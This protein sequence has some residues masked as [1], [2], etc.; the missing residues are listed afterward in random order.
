MNRALQFPTRRQAICLTVTVL[1]LSMAPAAAWAAAPAN[2][3][4]A[5][6]ETI[7]LGQHVT[8]DTS[9]ATTDALDTAVNEECGAPA[10]AASVWYSYT[11]DVDGG[12]LLDMSG[13]DYTAGALVFEGAP[14]AESLIACGPGVVGWGT[15]AGSTYSVMVLDDQ[16]DG[17]PA[18]GG[19][20]EMDVTEAPAPPSLDL[21]VSPRAT[22]TKDGTALVT[23][24]Y[25][26]TDADFI[27]F[28]G[29]LRQSVG[30]FVISGWGY[31]FEEGTC[32]GERHDFTLPITGDNGKFSGGKAASITFSY[33][34]GLLECTDGYVEQ[35][36]RLTKGH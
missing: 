22:V 24:T 10:T 31:T 2:D 26:C 1:G 20:L 6:A 5:G 25:S 17:N 27:E 14:S 3:T 36:I 12:V 19:T 28:E 30:R 9:E 8:Q 23:G 11:A 4:P 34:C 7:T 21:E 15:S 33:A 13:S 32:D 16:Q 18:P 29:E 35:Q